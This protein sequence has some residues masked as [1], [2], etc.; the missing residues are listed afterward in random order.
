M[1]RKPD[2]ELKPELYAAPKYF[3][4]DII[5]D[6]RQM[7]KWLCTR[8]IPDVIPNNKHSSMKCIFRKTCVYGFSYRFKCVYGHEFGKRRF[9]LFEYHSSR[10]PCEY[11]LTFHVKMI[12]QAEAKLRG[13]SIPSNPVCQ[14]CVLYKFVEGHNHPDVAYLPGVTPVVEPIYVPP[15]P[16]LLDKIKSGS[17]FSF[18]TPKIPT[19]IAKTASSFVKEPQD[20]RLI[21]EY[22]RVSMRES[23]AI[24]PKR[25][26]SKEAAGYDLWMGQE[27]IVPPKSIVLADSA[28]E[29]LPPKNSYIA[30]GER[31]SLAKRGLRILTTMHNIYED[32]PSSSHLFI[33]FSNPT[34]DQIV[35]PA[36]KACAQLIIKQTTPINLIDVTDLE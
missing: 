18:S 21:S 14:I 11:A 26:G 15:S 27:F 35:I 9:S 17:S 25:G 16:S 24:L 4:L 32:D 3:D 30:I 8:F 2:F 13:I 7:E 22:L 6:I 20:Y 5:P 23:D 33:V 34:K 31:S 19:P 29:I 1:G 12:S 36:S 10:P 28:L